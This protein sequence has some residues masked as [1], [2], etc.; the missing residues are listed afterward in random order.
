MSTCPLNLNGKTQFCDLLVP[1]AVGTVR[2]CASPTPTRKTR[3]KMPQSNMLCLVGA[4]FAAF[5]TDKPFQ[6]AK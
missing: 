6:Y 2:H 1:P 4:I 5:K 3:A